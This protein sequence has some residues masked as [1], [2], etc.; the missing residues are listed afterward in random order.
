[1]PYF[2]ALLLF[3]LEAEV[4]SGGLHHYFFNSSG[5]LH[6]LAISGLKRLNAPISLQALKAAAVKLGSVYPEDRD[7]RIDLLKQFNDDLD[8]F[9]LDTNV[10]Q[11]LPERFCDMALNL[12]A[13]KFIN[14]YSV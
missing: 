2:E 4:L 3:W 8:P 11:E 9:D 12:L 7:R 6:P 10:L 1:M 14:I 5:D 13:E